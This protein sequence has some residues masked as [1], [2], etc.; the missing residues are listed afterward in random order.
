MKQNVC[1]YGD[2][3]DGQIVAYLYDESAGEERQAFER[4]LTACALCRTE[5]DGLRGVRAEIGHWVSPEPD[6]VVTIDEPSLAMP[7]PVAP[8]PASRHRPVWA[9][10][11]AAALI[12]GVGAGVANLDISYSPAQGL[13][14]RTGWRHAPAVAQT[15]ATPA[16]A[17]AVTWQSEMKALEARL[18]TEL[19]SHQVAPPSSD[20]AELRQVRAWLMDSEQRQRRE[21][22]LR[23]A[24]MAR[25]VES[26]RQSDLARIDRNLGILQRDTGME[27]MRTR[28]QM[29]SLAQRVSQ[30]P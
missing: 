29:N 19:A 2:A 7:M 16:A 26:Q 30:Q 21:V 3:R 10:A 28:E 8:P 27:V 17:P 20:E 5:V 15:V 13:S 12:L 4:H 9:Q 11:L 14:V 25:E 23:M 18:R 22:A 24:E 1:S 6:F